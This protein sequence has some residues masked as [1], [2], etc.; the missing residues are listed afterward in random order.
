VYS[1]KPTLSLL[2]M[3]ENASRLASSAAKSRLRA[4]AEPKFPDALMSTSRKIVSSRSSVYFLTNGLPARAVTFQSM[5]RTSSPGLYS[6][7]S[8]KSIP[9]PLNTE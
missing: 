8:S 3:A 4:A 6:R 2:R 7:T 5:V 1:S 9:R